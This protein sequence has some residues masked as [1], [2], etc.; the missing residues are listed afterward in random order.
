VEWY[1]PGRGAGRA[2]LADQV[3]AMA[4]DGLRTRRR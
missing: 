1:R 4:F 2:V 3:C